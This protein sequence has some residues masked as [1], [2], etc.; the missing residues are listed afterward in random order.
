MKNPCAAIFSPGSEV[1]I[2]LP[3]GQLGRQPESTN[4]LTLFLFLCYP[5][6]KSGRRFSQIG[7]DKASPKKPNFIC[8]IFYP[9]NLRSSASPIHERK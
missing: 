5:N 7:A 6:K 9:E 4:Q 3:T 8:F 2:I 1:G